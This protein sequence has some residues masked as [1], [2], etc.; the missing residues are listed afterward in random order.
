MGVWGVVGAVLSVPLSAMVRII[1]CEMQH[2][3]VK[4]IRRL[5]EVKPEE[6]EQEKEGE[7]EEEE[8]E[9]ETEEEVK[10]GDSPRDEVQGRESGSDDVYPV[11]ELPQVRS[12][13]NRAPPT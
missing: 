12:N 2:P 4:P 6:E 5:I 13:I 7:E 8:V 1:L 3:F 11:I 10:P 9:E